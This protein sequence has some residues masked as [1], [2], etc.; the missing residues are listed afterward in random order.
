VLS[1]QPRTS[2]G[3]GKSREEIIGDISKGIEDKTPPVIDLDYIIEKYPTMYTESMNTVLTQEVIRYN[4][5]LSIMAKM[6]KDVQK[7]LKGEIVMSEDLDALATSMFNNQVP[8]AFGKVGFLSL[9]PLSSWIN[10]LND[11]I[12][13]I[14]SWIDVGMPA[15]YWLSGFFFP[16][17]FFTGAL[18][19]YARK[20]TIAIDELDY[21]FK[22]H[23]EIDPQDVT[24]KPADGVFCFGMYFEGARW[25]KT[26][27]M[28]DESKPKQLYVEIPL[29]WYVPKRNRVKAETGIYNCPVYKVLS[30]T[31]LLSTTGHSTNFVQYIELPTK[32]EEAKWIRGGVAAF[33]ALRY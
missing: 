19:N 16:Q 9:K 17:A 11:R 21:D 26:I 32:E 18:Q 33:L 5:L 31:G 20:H 24:E 28:L 8:A 25:N 23:D 22:V 13:F 30:R 6:L 15:A 2:S 12:K 27:H 4:R 10:D 29:I 3:G 7:A 1:V 14:T